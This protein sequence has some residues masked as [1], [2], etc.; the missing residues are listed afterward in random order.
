M[1]NGRLKREN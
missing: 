1:E